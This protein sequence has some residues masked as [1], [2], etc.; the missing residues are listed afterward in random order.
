MQRV[1]KLVETVGDC[2]VKLINQ[3]PTSQIMA[4]LRTLEQDNA[5]LRA[6][7]MD[8]RKE[9]QASLEEPTEEPAPAEESG[10]MTPRRIP[11]SMPP[12]LH[13][14]LSDVFFGGGQV[15]SHPGRWKIG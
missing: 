2:M 4:R 7:Q 1:C 3:N 8:T 14:P 6:S 10:T 12:P 13:S 5:N 11:P 9:G 15:L